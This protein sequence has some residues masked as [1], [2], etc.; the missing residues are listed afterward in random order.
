VSTAVA[1]GNGRRLPRDEGGMDRTNVELDRRRR[2]RAATALLVLGIAAV[3]A[4][5]HDVRAR[6]PGPPGGA[7]GGP[8][9]RLELLFSGDADDVA[10]TVDGQLVVRDAHTGHIVIDNVPA[11]AVDVVVA[12]GPGE[13]AM[14]VWIH[15]GQTTTVPLGGGGS[16]SALGPITSAFVSL[17][18]VVL[19][20]LLN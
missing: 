7:P 12:S 2:R 13:K 15:D 14:E 3:G 6:Y 10:V 4:C 11:G 5:A 19:Y 18:S 16:G 17:A 9:G 1:R 20:A 8:V